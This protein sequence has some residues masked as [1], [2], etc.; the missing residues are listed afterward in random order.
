MTAP[1]AATLLRSFVTG[2][3]SELP[4][5]EFALSRFESNSPDFEFTSISAGEADE[6]DAED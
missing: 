4:A 1:V 6:D 2:E 5:E 3:A